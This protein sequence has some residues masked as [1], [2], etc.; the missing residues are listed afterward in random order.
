MT[1]QTDTLVGNGEP[2]LKLKQMLID[3]R[4]DTSAWLDSIEK[5]KEQ[6]QKDG[7]NEQ[8]AILLIKQHLPHDTKTRR[9]LKYLI[10]EKP[11]IKE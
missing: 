4:S 2:S 7:F 11:R 6:A 9:R 1:S 10:F 3:F 5:I 8:E